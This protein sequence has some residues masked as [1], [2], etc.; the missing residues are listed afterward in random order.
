MEQLKIASDSCL[1]ALGNVSS[2][3]RRNSHAGQQCLAA[4]MPELRGFWEGIATADQSC[5][6]PL[7]LQQTAAYAS[8]ITEGLAPTL[9]LVYSRLGPS[10][11][12]QEA[13]RKQLKSLLCC[14]Y[15]AFF[16]LVFA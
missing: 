8:A 14:G 2:V 7:Q 5:L 6:Q 9:L 13:Q 1:A 4:L 3:L 12:R 16:F 15:E 11:T 10:T